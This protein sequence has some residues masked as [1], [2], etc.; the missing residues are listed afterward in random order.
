MLNIRLVRL[1]VLAVLLMVNSPAHCLPAAEIS[2]SSLLDDMTNL[3]KMAE[4]PDPPFIAKQFSS[5]DRAST[6]P[7]DP[8]TWFANNDCGN[9][10]RVE[11]RNGH[12]EYVMADMPGPGAIT[13]IWSP[14]PG[15]T[16]RIYLDGN[17]KPAL[18]YAMADLLGGKHPLLPPPIAVDLSMGWNLYFPIPYAKSCKVTCDRG[19]QY[20]HVGYRTYPKGTE[21]KTFTDEQLETTLRKGLSWVA[22]NLNC[23]EIVSPLSNPLFLFGENA[24]KDV[25][26]DSFYKTISPGKNEVIYFDCVSQ[27]RRCILR[28]G[29]RLR[30]FQ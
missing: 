6:T 26:V 19:G 28:G 17:E 3:T 30:F 25:A 1:A 14:N 29:K 2:M 20:Y 9:Y 4:F 27:I 24:P 21:V 15:G 13:R 5:Y 11:D 8:K 12:K 22:N 10:L 7:A 18:E 23:P 16:L